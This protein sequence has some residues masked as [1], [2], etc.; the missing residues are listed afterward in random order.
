[1]QIHTEQSSAALL[2]RE[3]NIEE[4]ITKMILAK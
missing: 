4:L 2:L 3:T 1:M